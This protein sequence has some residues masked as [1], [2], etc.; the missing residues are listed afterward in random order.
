MSVSFSLEE[1]VSTGTCYRSDVLDSNLETLVENLLSAYGVALPQTQ[2]RRY[3]KSPFRPDFIARGS[4]GARI[5]IEVRQAALDTRSLYTIYTW[6]DEA[7][8]HNVIDRLLIV[9]DEDPS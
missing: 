6:H 8:S 5:A 3:G 7:R 4:G 1:H 9:T 2:L